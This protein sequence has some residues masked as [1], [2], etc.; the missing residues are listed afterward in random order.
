MSATNYTC[1]LQTTASPIE[2]FHAINKVYGW[3]SQNFEGSA[4]EV[5]DEFSVRFGDVHYSK[6]KIIESVPGKSVVWQVTDS[7]LNF[8]KD[9]TEWNGTTNRFDIS[10]VDGHT[11]IVFTHEGLVPQIECFKDCS[12]GWN[13]YLQGSLKPFMDTG[14]GKPQLKEDGCANAN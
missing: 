14:V 7:K 8:L 10:T 13:Y 5:G 4:K 2:A 1:T 12:N 6:H 11:Q 3:W 9:K